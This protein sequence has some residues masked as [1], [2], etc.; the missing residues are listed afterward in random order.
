MSNRFKGG[1]ERGAMPELHGYLGNPVLSF[2]GRLLFRIDTGDFH[3][4][5]RGFLLELTHR[6]RN[7]PLPAPRLRS[8]WQSA[9]RRRLM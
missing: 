2:L 3:W 1:I 7:R 6:N 5:M 4:G 9:W 8:C